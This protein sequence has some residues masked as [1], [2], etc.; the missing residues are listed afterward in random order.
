M[1]T[2]ILNL[3]KQ[4]IVFIFYFLNILGILRFKNYYIYGN[5]FL[6]KS[7]NLPSQFDFRNEG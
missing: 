4:L 5:I 7:V 2:K 1:R 3:L 6:L